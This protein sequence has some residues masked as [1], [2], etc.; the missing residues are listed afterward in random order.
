[1]LKEELKKYV[2]SDENVKG[3]IVVNRVN[4]E[5]IEFVIKESL[6]LSEI[7]NI[8]KIA[9]D[10]IKLYENTKPGGDLITI[11]FNS[12]EYTVLID[13]YQ[14]NNKVLV[15]LFRPNFVVIK[16]V[17]EKAKILQNIINIIKSS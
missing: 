4:G 5:P 1:M 13:D 16:F 9:V 3:L 11:L 17:D 2:E 14:Q 7:N 15:F 12:K 10:M 6:A 8:S